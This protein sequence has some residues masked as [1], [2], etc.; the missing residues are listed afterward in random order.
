[1]FQEPFQVLGIR[2]PFTVSLTALAIM[3]FTFTPALSGDI[4]AATP[5]HSAEI[6]WIKMMNAPTHPA[7]NPRPDLRPSGKDTDWQAMIDAVWGPGRI[8]AEQSSIFDNFITALDQEYALFRNR[9]VDLV[10]LA[11]P[12]VS[13]IQG[14]VSKG[15]FQGIM[16]KMCVALQNGHTSFRNGDVVN[17]TPEPGVPLLIGHRYL[18]NPYFGACLTTGDVGIFA[19]EVVENHPLGLEVGDVILGYDGRP[20]DELYHELLEAEL[21]VGGGGWLTS[22]ASYDYGWATAAGSN[23]HLFETIDILK[24]D[25]GQTEHLPTSLMV[26]SGVDL[27]VY[28]A[29][30]L[31]EYI[32]HPASPDWVNWGVLERGA[33]RIGFIIVEA[34]IEYVEAAWWQA[35]WEMV[36]DPELDG[37][38]I[39]F[40]NNI[41]GNMYLSNAGLSLL[42]EETVQT[43]SFGYRINPHNHWYMSRFNDSSF[44]DIPGDPTEYFDK[45]IAVLLGPKTISSGDQVA[46]RMTYHPMVR[47]FGRPT[48]ASFDSPVGY[49]LN[50]YEEFSARYSKYDA[51]RAETP[52]DYLSYL[53]FP[54]D[55]EIWLDPAD[56]RQGIDTVIEAAIA[57]IGPDVNAVPENE[58]PVGSAIVGISPN[59]CNPR[60]VVK[61]KIQTAGPCRLDVIDLAG[62]LIWSE[63]WTHLDVGN[64]E[65]L[66]DGKTASGRHAA[67][68]AYMVRLTAPDLVT[69]SRLTLVR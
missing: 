40:R 62:H 34:W 16:T 7:P 33:S 46:L 67:S 12:H 47:T 27:S 19:Y 15:R 64:H 59:P 38:I 29:D 21:P 68:G 11:T 30:Q 52:Q 5:D 49:E 61:F 51:G 45:P 69:G 60:T 3:L 41:G 17:T 66:W 9:D 50:Q 54:V 22:D 39:D 4:E 1:M 10:G 63:D 25:S 48:S 32:D 26:N 35:C 18:T 55:E 2:V 31:N 37:L 42:F 13:E 43:V 53:G 20:W 44:Y 23:W 36:T 58:A 65:Y 56:C 14:G 57:W 6:E 8:A 28:C 24:F